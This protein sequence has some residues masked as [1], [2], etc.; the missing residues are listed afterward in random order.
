MLDVIRKGTNIS[1]GDVEEAIGL[2]R[3]A[4]LRQL[5]ALRDAGLIERVGK[6]PQDPRAYWRVR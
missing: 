2:S 6:S 4:V 1:T 5:Y 3:P